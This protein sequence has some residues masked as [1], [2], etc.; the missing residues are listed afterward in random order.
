[1]D[2][3]T[4]WTIHGAAWSQL[5]KR[6]YPSLGMPN[7]AYLV[8][9]ICC[10]TKWKKSVTKIYLSYDKSRDLCRITSVPNYIALTH[11]GRDKM[12]AVSQ[13][14]LSNAFSWMK[15]L[16][17][18]LRFHW[19][20]FQ[21]FQIND[22]PSWVQIMAWRRSGDKPLSEPMMVSLSTH[23]CI[24]RPQRVNKKKMAPEMMKLISH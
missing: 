17:F 23:I 24:T 15:M 2:W 3:Q 6:W 4:N 19:S 13:T 8:T 9:V 20:L 22:I 12:T 10:L 16:A 5:K 1:M 21:R 7:L 18:R 11:W 14:T